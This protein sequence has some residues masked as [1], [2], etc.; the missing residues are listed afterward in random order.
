M[1]VQKSFDRI[2]QWQ[3]ERDQRRKDVEDIICKEL[4]T[5]TDK[6]LKKLDRFNTEIDNFLKW[7][8]DSVSSKVEGAEKYCNVR[9]ERI[10]NEIARIDRYLAKSNKND[11]KTEV[12]SEQEQV[13]DLT[14]KQL[15]QAFNYTIFDTILFSITKGQAPDFTLISQSVL[16]ETAYLGI[17]RGFDSYILQEVP[18][19]A[20]AA[21][22]QGRAILE[23]LRDKEERFLDDPELWDV[24]APQIQAWWLNSA[25]SLIY[26]DRDEDWD[27]ITFRSHE[28]MQ[29][30]SANEYSRMQ[31]FPAI[32][33]LVELAKVKAMDVSKH[34]NFTKL[35]TL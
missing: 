7:N 29:R 23:E 34:F 21:I 17:L 27:N 24:Y 20:V 6:L 5:A 26:G 3:L 16:F 33:D 22:L 18:Q 35:I 8:F 28:E 15:L 13:V 9:E 10:V 30:W 19:G 31:Y 11:Q 12:E 1:D 14:D 4:D 32:Y 2:T 25:L